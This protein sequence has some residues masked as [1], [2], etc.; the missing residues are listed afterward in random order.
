MLS[1]FPKFRNR[2]ILILGVYVGCLALWFML[3]PGINRIVFLLVG[4]FGLF[5]VTL[6][7]YMNAA[8]AHTQ[9]LNRLYNQLDAEGFL[10]D[11]EPHLSANVKNQNLYLMIRLHV[12]NAYA[13]QGRF[14]DAIKLLSAIQ[15]K[16]GKPEK[17][18]IARFAVVSNLCYCAEQKRDVETAKAYLD[19]LRTLKKQLEEIQE[20]KPVKK[21]MAFNTELNEQCMKFLQTG[22][23]DINTLKTQVQQNNTQQLHRV[24]TSLWIARA[25]LAE[26]NRR[27]AENILKQIVK[28]APDL[29]P[30]KAAAEIL[31]GL[32]VK[33][34]EGN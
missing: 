10:R 2:L 26:Q 11:Y 17:T 6:S 29:Y 28:L 23:A 27:E 24:T 13:A 5:V 32:P 22:K 1:L 31:S 19:E 33:A 7:Q 14:D 30:G 15:I 20:K 3:D 34:N 21:R 9:Q 18:L 4:V 8:S 25:M 12:S 16:D